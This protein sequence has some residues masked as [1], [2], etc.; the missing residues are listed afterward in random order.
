MGYPYPRSPEHSGFKKA[1]IL[2]AVLVLSVLF[3][4]LRTNE[5]QEVLPLYSGIVSNLRVIQ[6]SKQLWAAE[7]K[8]TDEDT[9][10]ELDLAPYF[11]SGR[12]PQPV[13]G[14]TYRI[15]PVGMNPVAV[16]HK[17]IRVG[18]RTIEAGGEVRLDNEP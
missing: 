2:V 15:N 17:R 10:T 13:I 1:G 12:F 16:V 18:S 6:N 8:R 11:N 14:E 3:L 5:S 4:R 9:P 7:K